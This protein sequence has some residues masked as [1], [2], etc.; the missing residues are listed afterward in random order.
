MTILMCE[1]EEITMSDHDFILAPST[2]TVRFALSPVVNNLNSLAMI[3]DYEYHSGHGD[4]VE[5]T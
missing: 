2:V 4:W 1:R 3:S 5:Q